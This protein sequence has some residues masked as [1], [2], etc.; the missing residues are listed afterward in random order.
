MKRIIVAILLLVVALGI[1]A[2]AF[3]FIKSSNL[4]IQ[5]KYFSGTPDVTVDEIIETVTAQV[6]E[7][8]SAHT[9]KTIFVPDDYATIK[10]AISAA[11]AG[12]TVIVRDG[13]YKGEGNRNIRFEGKAIALRSENGPEACIID[14]ESDGRGF[15]FDERET[16]SSILDG[17]TITNA[18]VVGSELEG[19]GGGIACVGSCSPTIINCILINNIAASSG[20]GIDCYSNASPKIINCTISQNKASYGGGIGTNFGSSPIIVDCTI[21]K[22]KS[23]MGG[24]LACNNR[25]SPQVIR[26][27]ITDNISDKGTAVYSWRESSP[28]FAE[29]VIRGNIPRKGKLDT[30]TQIE[31]RLFSYPTFTNCTIEEKS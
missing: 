23:S 22:N 2:V 15:H 20:G 16:S 3:F 14:C 28:H 25:C 30:A 11:V 6:K 1:T 9:G 26:T 10:A 5:A 4:N 31:T 21:A 13:V 17:L 19:F 27:S 18:F 12:D 7:A 24:G 8:A 29:C